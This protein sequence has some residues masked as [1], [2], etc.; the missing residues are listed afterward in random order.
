MAQ[1]IKQGN[2]FGRIGTGVGKGLAE[3][4]PKEIERGRL[5]SGLKE[6]GERKDQ[7]PFQQFSALASVPGVTP[8]MLQS[9]TDLLRQQA[10][11][12]SLKNQY[13]GAG[14]T[15]GYVPSQEELSEP[16]KGEIPSLANPEST[17]QSYKEFIPPSKQQERQQAFDN[18]NKNPARYDYNFNNALSEVEA[19]TGRNQEIQ[20]AYQGQESTAVDKETKLKNALDNEKTRLDVNAVPPKAYQK[21]EERVLNSILPIKDGGEGLTQEQAI[22]K[23]SKQ[24]DQANRNYLDLG[25]LSTWSP[26]DFNRRTNALQKEFASRGEQQMMM[27]QLV[28]EYG[29]SPMYAA[30]KAYPPDAT[31]SKA[32][33]EIPNFVPDL[34]GAKQNAVNY[35]ALKKDMGKTGSPLSVAY[36]L[37]KKQRDPRPWLEYLDKNKDDLEV[38]QADQLT[39]NINRIDL[40]DMW[41]QAWE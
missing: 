1:Y 10:Y 32:L 37:Q 17:A 16:L 22:K 9:G 34:I 40:K 27:D 13:E 18:F 41:L 29:V 28:S 35:Q 6:L 31:L 38:W 39:K 25:S 14:Q 3:S 2:L 11:L 26:S 30:H 12:N 23:Y 8:Q 7:T 33:K 36:E 21:F 24:L 15:K 19:S 20:K 5:A 4:L